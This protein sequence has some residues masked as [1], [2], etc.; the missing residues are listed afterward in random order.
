MTEIIQGIPLIYNLCTAQKEAATP[1]ESLNFPERAR[2]HAVTSVSFKRLEE[3]L[4]EHTQNVIA[5]K[6]EGHHLH[7]INS[8][9]NFPLDE[10]K[11]MIQAMKPDAPAPPTAGLEE[12]T[13]QAVTAEGSMLEAGVQ[14]LLEHNA[15][16][17]NAHRFAM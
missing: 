4:H 15:M 3:T 13:R 11:Q 6:Q 10:L 9:D 2:Y 7:I 16:V 12:A 1:W 17:M 5:Q 8:M 14:G